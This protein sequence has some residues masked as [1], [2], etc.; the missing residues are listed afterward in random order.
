MKP[1]LSIIVPY[2]DRLEHLRRFVPHIQRYFA[3]D[4][5]DRD[6][7][8]ALTIVEQANRG[9]FNAGLL[10][11]IGF[12]LSRD[13][14]DYF[15]FH[16]VDY[17]P[18]WADYSFSDIPTR[19]IWHG[20]DSRP[21]D[22]G[23]PNRLR[24]IHETL[25]GAVVMLSKSHFELTNGYSNGYWGWG[26]E[27]TDLRERCLACGLDIALRDGTFEALTHLNRGHNEDMTLSESGMR[28]HHRY[29]D[30]LQLLRSCQRDSWDGLKD[31]DFKVVET[32]NL[33]PIPGQRTP[34]ALRIVRVDF[35]D[36]TDR[37]I[38]RHSMR[39]PT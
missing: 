33:E 19:V 37:R 11:N 39:L 21:R 2:R 14:H 17:L 4:K 3:R 28:N 18:V 8:Y 20:A 7:P 9:E 5:I 27:D 15:C 13:N 10:R 26:Y 32:V 24:H 29:I 6:I 23:E 12:A 36:Q 30:Q 31:I 34:S 22:E 35:G 16:D 1:A 25:F 38:L